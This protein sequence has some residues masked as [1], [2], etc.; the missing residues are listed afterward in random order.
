MRKIINGKS[1]Q[2]YEVDVDLGCSSDIAVGEKAAK[3]IE[4]ALKKRGV[5]D[6][7]LTFSSWRVEINV[8]DRKEL[9]YL[10]CLLDE[11]MNE[12]KSRI[13]KF[14]ITVSTF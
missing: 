13:N 2:V 3:A 5:V 12:E 7:E 6:Y 4:K 1:K 9:Y 8:Y 10:I 14:E 11:L